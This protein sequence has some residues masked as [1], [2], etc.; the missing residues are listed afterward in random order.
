MDKYNRYTSEWEESGAATVP[1]VQNLTIVSYNVLL[2]TLDGKRRVFPHIFQHERRYEAI[3]AEL[4][5]RDPTFI[6]LNE[7]TDT[8]MNLLREDEWVR[9]Q[10]YM[11]VDSDPAAAHWNV[12]LSKIPAEECHVFSLLNLKKRALTNLYRLTYREQEL[13]LTFTSVHFTSMDFNVKKRWGEFND[14]HERLNALDCSTHILAGDMNLHSEDENAIFLSKNYKD[15]WLQINYDKEGYTF[16]SKT[17]R[18]IKAMFGG[19]EKRRMR[20]DRILL[21]DPD[22]VLKTEK[23]EVIG[24]D[25]IY[26][27]MVYN[28]DTKLYLWYLLARGL[29]SKNTEERYGRYLHNSD[30][31]GL[32]A[33]LTTC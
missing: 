18:L 20:L 27:E 21:N 30:H 8:M 29:S 6:S 23:M 19:F 2:D 11:S 9:D 4:K 32:S 15:C 14:L 25:P 10:Y 5:R 13:R 24:K 22:N 17:N 31:Y 28:G 7:V 1:N 26:P 3:L 16:D 33:E 12:I